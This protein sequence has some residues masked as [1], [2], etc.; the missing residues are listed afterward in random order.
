MKRNYE[1]SAQK[2]EKQKAKVGENVSQYKS[3]MKYLTGKNSSKNQNVELNKRIYR[4]HITLRK[5]LNFV[6]LYKFRTVGIDIIIYIFM[7]YGNKYRLL[8][9]VKK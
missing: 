1:S 7:S 8:K 2:Q 9:N 6:M 5:H 4:F 3:L